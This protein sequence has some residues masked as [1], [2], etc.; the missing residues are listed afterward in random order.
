[1]EGNL[2]S[3]KPIKKLA[4]RHLEL[5]SKDTMTRLILRICESDFYCIVLILWIPFTNFLIT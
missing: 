5:R 1:M 4:I 2:A 3:H